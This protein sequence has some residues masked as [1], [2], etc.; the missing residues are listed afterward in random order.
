MNN[1]FLMFG[2][3]TV[4]LKVAALF[5]IG[6][7]TATRDAS[8]WVR[9]N[10][11]WTCRVGAEGYSTHLARR[12][13]YPPQAGQEWCWRSNDASHARQ[14][15]GRPVC[16]PRW[17]TLRALSKTPID[18]HMFRWSYTT[19]KSNDSSCQFT[20]RRLSVLET[21]GANRSGR[22]VARSCRKSG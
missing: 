20:G 13:S 17:E 1:Y 14:M 15:Y 3:A 18:D 16:S 5:L 11:S 22:T 7:A 21:G 2:I 9:P 12:M 10:S 8:P 19:K 6:F 4:T